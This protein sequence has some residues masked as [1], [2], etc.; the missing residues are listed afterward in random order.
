MH[1]ISELLEQLPPIKDFHMS[2]PGTA[3]WITWEGDLDPAVIQTLQDYGGMSIVSTRNQAMWFFFSN[4]VFLALARLA[5]WAQFNTLSV[6]IQALPTRLQLSVRRD[7][8]LAFD[9]SL[10]QQE[11]LIPPKLLIWVHPK[12]FENAGN[13][14]GISFTPKPEPRGMASASWQILD[15]DARLPYTSSQGWYALLRPLGNPL[16][17][18]FQQGWHTMLRAIEALMKKHKLKFLTHDYFVMTPLDNLR[19]L[20]LWSK[21]ILQLLSESKANNE[22][23]WPCVSVV[24]D[25]KG[26]NFSND[27]PQKIGI[28]WDNLMPN[29]PYMSYRN[30]FLL[31]ENF[32]ITDLHYSATQ[33]TMDSWCTVSLG[34][35]DMSEGSFIPVLVA[36]QLVIGEGEQCF[37]CGVRNHTHNN[38]PTKQLAC[39]EHDVWEHFETLN[40]ESINEAFR[41]VEVG[42]L[43]HGAAAFDTWL[44]A[45]GNT[46]TLVRSIFEINLPAQLRAIEHIWLS[47]SRTFV[48]PSAEEGGE[49]KYLPKDDSPAWALLERFKKIAETEYISFERDVAQTIQRTPRDARLHTLLGFAALERRDYNRAHKH[50]KEAEAL[51]SSALHQYWHQ[52][53][54]ARLLEIQGRPAEAMDIFQ[55]IVRINPQWTDA[56]YRQIVCRV[57]MGFAEQVQLPMHQLIEQTPNTFNRFLIDPELERGH[58]VLLTSLHPLWDEAQR[59]KNEEQTHIQRLSDELDTWFDSDH[60]VARLF[61]E[62]I[63]ELQQLSAITNYMAFLKIV[64]LRPVVEND[65]STQIQVEVDNIKARYKKYLS[66][67]EG[68]RDESS[69]FPFPRI[70][71]DFN[72]DFNN[73]AT[74]LSWAFG[75]N[76][77][78]PEAF[79]KALSHIPTMVATLEKLEKRLRFLR[80]VR[81]STLYALI[82]GKTFFWIEMGL[83]L[84]S[85]ICVPT[86]L[87]FGNQIGLGW[88]Q[89]LVKANHWQLQKVLFLVITATSLGVAALRT[90]LVFE[91]Q[92]A[93]LLA[94]A[95]EQRKEMQKQ[96]LTAIVESKTRPKKTT[97]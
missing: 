79:K 53:L 51:S 8:S 78:T 68:I 82:L 7:M 96:R 86:I 30:A 33:T 28:K 10:I 14:P 39:H 6:N 18:R 76:F 35:A 15:A 46:G 19:H 38:C 9:A 95:R 58:L 24:I 97:A 56:D 34:D 48:K 42:L 45:V 3:L 59:K 2:S 40:F 13:L 20:R 43:E 84:V 57:K 12:V 16:D 41:E 92:R 5:V 74:I 80:M 62:R 65:I 63:K 89:E 69:W 70:L 88:L 50:W 91:R 37:Y 4:D 64:Q 75:A 60:P 49:R 87:L 85:L 73:C 36:E 55:E 32:G 66:I 61:R 47:T 54:R 44:H 67:L 52:Y 11:I 72:R 93:K 94:S 23:H 77:N 21:D 22:E 83:L 25:R 1:A 27:L 71:V 90:T 26:L 29:H 81:D 17:K 31:G